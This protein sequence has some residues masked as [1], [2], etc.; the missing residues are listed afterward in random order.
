VEQIEFAVLQFK[1]YVKVVA[2]NPDTAFKTVYTA[3]LRSPET[4]ELFLQ[5]IDAESFQTYRNL[6]NRHR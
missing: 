5:N 2:T 4:K 1:Q 6:L 3:D